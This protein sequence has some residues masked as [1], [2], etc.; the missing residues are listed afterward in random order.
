VARVVRDIDLFLLVI[1][2]LR[3]PQESISHIL[4]QMLPL[5][6]ASDWLKLMTNRVDPTSKIPLAYIATMSLT[7][8]LAYSFLP[9]R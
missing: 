3:I 8:V 5:D 9:L 4:L 7:L 1:S 6:L 2:F